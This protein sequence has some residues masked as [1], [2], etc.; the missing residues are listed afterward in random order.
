MNPELKQVKA[1]FLEA[2]EKQDPD[3]RS[4]FLD[5]A[6]GDDPELRGRVEALLKAHA[7][8]E[9]LLDKGA[10]AP[11]AT[12][13][14]Q[15]SES[16]GTQLGP[17]KLLQPIGEGG[18]G[19]VY[20]AEQSEPVAR[21]VALK[22]I[23]PGMDTRQ[24]IARFEAE[25]QALAIMDHPNI[26]KVLDAG[27]T[28]G[29]R[30]YFAMELV[31]GVPITK[32]CDEHHLTPKQRLDLFTQVCQAVQHAHQK[33]I[34]HRDLKPSNVLVAEYDDQP[35]P[36]IIDFG[37]AKA[38]DKRLTDKTMFTE[39]GQVVGTLEYMSPE[40]AK[41]NQLDIDTRS[42]IYSLGVL[43]YELL[44]GSTP[45]TKQRLRSA[46]IDE[47]MRI[48]RE[49]E[50]PKPSTRL[51]TIE[52]LPSVA[53]NRSM[54]PQKLGMLVRGDLDWIVMKALEK[55][56]ARRYETASSFAEDIRRYLDEEPVLACP[57]SARYKFRKF[58]RRNKFVLA[59]GS[60][61]AAAI[62]LGLFGT[63]WQML[64][65]MRAE[66]L[67]V[68]EADEART[69]AAIAVAVN[70]FINDDLLGQA[71]P[72]QEPDPD[73]KVRTV[74]DRAAQTI[75]DRFEDQPLVKA[76]IH[77]TLSRTLC[78]IGLYN[79]AERHSE[80]NLQLCAHHRGAEHRDTLRA[81][82]E[83]AL[84]FWRQG[85]YAEAEKLHIEVLE[86]RKRLL[87]PAH[88]D[89][90]RSMAN[91]AN[92]IWR[93]GRHAEAEQMYRT[94]LKS[95][96][97]DSNATVINLANVIRDQGRVAEALKMYRD[98]LAIQRNTGGTRRPNTL[99][100]MNNLAN[101]YLDLGRI[102]EAE[103]LISEAME[104]MK[105]V[106]APEHNTTLLLMKAQARVFRTQGRYAEALEIVDDVLKIQQRTLRADH[107]DIFSTMLERASLFS[108]QNLFEEAVDANQKIINLNPDY[109]K[110]YYNLGNALV[111]K[112]QLDIAIEAYHRAIEIKPD[113]VPVYLNLGNALNSKGQLD[114]A[115]EAYQKAIELKPDDERAHF[116]LGHAL[117]RKGRL[118]DAIAAYYEAINLKPD[119]FGAYFNLGT[120]HQSK[121]Q[122]DAAIAAYLE[123]NELRDNATVYFKL[124]N[125]LESKGQLDAAVEAY[126]R[127][128]ELDPDDAGVH[129]N[130]G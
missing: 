3:N 99:L 89:V 54:E 38:L 60:L 45:F 49:E 101:T 67:A 116:N 10:F 115:I 46:A 48:I 80:Q 96:R 73:L 13:D 52:S 25:E 24:V 15:V 62:V 79:E 94:I 117:H 18:M 8:D 127:A 39:L 112:G 6:C 31:K 9:S 41:V 109:F 113:L 28:D 2:L 119:Y 120:A 84:V 121:G 85:R 21:R 130:L 4:Q 17:Y 29:G 110:A 37:V 114:A 102:A 34:I 50:P 42:D 78:A 105:D 103:T 76:S 32:Y 1:I 71:N 88:P 126:E 104:I 59:A 53:A 107:P 128:I 55:D 65:A 40:Q 98:V 124:G 57:P 51:S 12:I 33:G 106:L 61:I 95:D 7:S 35:V 100:T 91:L 58:A 14:S 123:A 74:V 129:N 93:Q 23:K 92:T 22:I 44:T 26:A 81:K 66:Q 16:P 90:L 5:S 82:T 11:A 19:V 77:F 64:R 47:V 87:D 30:P 70:D 20:L 111:A 108:D 69:Q 72:L 36:K 75:G 122:L 86:I 83:C 27:S 43:L 63:T 97:L 56:R 125:A 68:Q 118:D